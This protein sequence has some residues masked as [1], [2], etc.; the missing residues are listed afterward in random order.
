MQPIHT[1]LPKS[2]TLASCSSCP[3]TANVH[4]Y[5]LLHLVFAQS[6]IIYNFAMLTGLEDHR[7]TI[8]YNLLRE[9]E[10]NYCD[11]PLFVC[12]EFNALAESL[13]D[14]YSLRT[15]SNFEEGLELYFV[16]VHIL[17]QHINYY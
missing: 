5:L 3:N 8:D 16:L 12:P 15:P 11:I 2:G 4:K 1:Y 6:D 13:M 9:I 17:D 14:Q 10:E 7:C